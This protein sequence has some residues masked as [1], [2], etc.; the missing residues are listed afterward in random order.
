MSGFSSLRGHERSDVLWCFLMMQLQVFKVTCSFRCWK[1]PRETVWFT[2]LD[3]DLRAWVKSW[4]HWSQ[5]QNP[6]SVSCSAADKLCDLGWVVSL[7]W[8]CFPSHS[9][10]FLS[11]WNESYW[12]QGLSLNMCMHRVS[13]YYCNAKIVIIKNEGHSRFQRTNCLYLRWTRFLVLFLF[14]PPQ[15][16]SFLIPRVHRNQFG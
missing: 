4:C 16:C 6:G 5:Y 1:T 7:L 2:R 13:R 10:P 14:E 11:V 8:V 9:L 15:M 12:A 3:W